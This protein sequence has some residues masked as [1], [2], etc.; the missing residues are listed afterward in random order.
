M[1][2]GLPSFTAPSPA[3]VQKFLRGVLEHYPE[4]LE[5]EPPTQ[6]HVATVE[7]DVAAEGRGSKPA[8]TDGGGE[9]TIQSSPSDALRELIAAQ[10]ARDAQE[11]LLLAANELVLAGLERL[12]ASLEREAV[13]PAPTDAEPPPV[14]IEATDDRHDTDEDDRVSGREEIGKRVGGIRFVLTA[15]NFVEIDE[16]TVSEVADTAKLLTEATRRMALLNSMSDNDKRITQR[17]L[18]SVW[19]RCLYSHRRSQCRTDLLLRGTWHNLS[20]PKRPEALISSK[21][22]SIVT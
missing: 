19:R 14:P 16:L 13:R 8:T 17:Q 22:H 3:S 18:E 21:L 2:R 1:D 4:W 7:P 11:R 10:R 6:P 20:S 15:D 5:I 12:A 9:P